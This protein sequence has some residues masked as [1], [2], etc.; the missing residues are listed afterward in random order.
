MIQHRQLWLDAPAHPSPAE[1]EVHVWRSRLD[2]DSAEV[3]SLTELLSPEERERASRYHF[4]KDRTRFVVARGMLRATLGRYLDIPSWLLRFTHNRYGKPELSDEAAVGR[5]RFNVSHSHDLALF[6][7][8]SGREVGVDIEQIR[9]DFAGMEVAER[10]FSPAEVT[11]LKALP[12]EARVRSFFD[13]WTRKEAYI[14]ARGEGLSHPLH[15][16]T[17]SLGSGALISLSTEDEQGAQRWSLM[18]LFPAEGYCAALAVEGGPP[19]LRCW[20]L[21]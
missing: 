4:E 7:F 1:N 2:R 10:F 19:S 15:R 21:P 13:C 14:K 3:W 18:E 16:F 12:P 11:A 9:A 8:A 6:A 5:L 20:E 17:V